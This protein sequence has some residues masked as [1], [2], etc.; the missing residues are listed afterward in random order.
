MIA[1]LRA[2]GDAVIAASGLSLSCI[3]TTLISTQSLTPGAQS[4]RGFARVNFGRFIFIL[5]F[6][7]F[8]G[9][10]SNFVFILEECEL[11]LFSSR[12]E[13]SALVQYT[14]LI[15]AVGHTPPPETLPLPTPLLRRAER[16]R[17]IPGRPEDLRT[18]DG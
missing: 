16:S 17:G 7:F 5:H 14:F 3:Y 9:Q 11:P 13:N 12:G 4:V 1:D 2:T 18:D 6:R 8:G 15:G 10:I